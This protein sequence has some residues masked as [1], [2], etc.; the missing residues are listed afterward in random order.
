MKSAPS[1]VSKRKP[2]GE[3]LVQMGLLTEAELDAALAF[4]REN[5]LKLGQALVALHLVNQSDLAEALRAQGTVHCIH[6]TPELVDPRRDLGWYDFA[7]VRGGPGAIG[8]APDR[9]ELQ[10]E[11]GPWRVYRRVGARASD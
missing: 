11:R 4:K 9:W 6:L 7:L 1:T 5:G 2:L 10:L 8:A 3:L